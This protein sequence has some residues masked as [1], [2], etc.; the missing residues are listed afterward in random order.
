MQDGT[1]SGPNVFF[2]APDGKADATGA[3]PADPLSLAGVQ[4]RIREIKYNG[5]LV[6]LLAGTYYL[7]ETLEFTSANSKV[8]AQQWWP[9]CQP[10][11][12]FAKV[13]F[14]GG[15]PLALDWKPF[16]DGIYRATVPADVRPFDQLFVNEKLQ[17]LARFPNFDPDAPFLNGTDADATSPK[18]V[19]GWK[20]PAGGFVHALHRSHWG[21]LHYRITGKTGDGQLQLEGGWGNNRPE[22]GPH[23]DH[24][25]VEG[26]FEELDAAGEWFF[27][28]TDRTLYFF[29][30]S[31]LDLATATVVVPQLETIVR[32]AGTRKAPV[33]G[34]RLGGIT[35]AHTLRT[36]MKKREPLQRSDWCVYRGGAVVFENTEGC[37][38]ILNTLDTVGGN[39]IFV[40]NYNR[41]LG[42][43]STHI[44]DAGANGI[45]FAGDPAAARSPLYHYSKSQPYETMD[46]E[47]GP[48][49]NNFPKDCHVSNTLIT[50]IGRVEKQ[51]AGVD[52]DLSSHITVRRCTIAEVPR[53]GINIGSGTWGGHLIADN[54]VFDTVRE[55][56]DHG[57]FN[58]WGRDRFWY[59]DRNAT[60]NR[61]VAKNPALP[62]LDVVE[63][64]TLRHNRWRCDR[65]WDI[66]LDDGSTNYVIEN[67]LCLNGG[68]KLREGYGRRVEN[69]ITVNN[70]IHFHAWY[71]NSGDIVRRNIV[72]KPHA[73]SSSMRVAVWGKE[74]DF[75][76]LHTADGTDAK[77]ATALQKLS[78]Q[79]AHSLTGDALFRN[80]AT[81][82]YRVEIGSPAFALGFVNYPMDDFGVTGELKKLAPKVKLPLVNGTDAHAVR[83]DGTVVVWQGARV[84]NVVGLTDIS[85]AGLSDETGVIVVGDAAKSAFLR[86]Y[87]VQDDDV[88]LGWGD[89]AVL[90]IAGLRAAEKRLS[91]PSV[92][93]VWRQQRAVPLPRHK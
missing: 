54:D 74:V 12:T 93:Y 73:P 66:D 24:R 36:F 71:E 29:P 83:R 84:K 22:H 77:P 90:D 41:F 76:L 38:F 30:P 3:T 82:D 91:V 43:D 8:Q 56:G 45:V 35:F 17:V 46:K 20:N 64:I 18:R 48:I 32:F 72:F 21:D 37:F 68:I 60:T 13:T 16:R 25:F 42:I 67:N 51:S 33:S 50:R 92:L 89:E 5:A 85:A 27:D 88:I 28:G 63:P 55:T 31:G 1:G 47:A 49:G 61:L 40:N 9:A 65:G 79:D 87:G 81:G 26:I 23:K 59:P 39:A 52:I 80:R 78:K 53:A 57:A 2:V 62:F 44:H 34:V 69:N 14:S 15:R 75:N 7:T 10:D 11:G 58:S 6:C 70:G 4:Q 86:Q 19:A